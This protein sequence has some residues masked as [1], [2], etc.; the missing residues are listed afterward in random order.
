MEIS[1]IILLFCD[2]LIVFAQCATDHIVY[3]LDKTW[4]INAVLAFHVGGDFCDFCVH[5]IRIKPCRLLRVLVL[6]IALRL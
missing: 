4:I 5:I 6:F 1:P 3:V 2:H